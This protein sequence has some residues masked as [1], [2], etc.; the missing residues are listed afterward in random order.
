MKVIKQVIRS[1]LNT[2]KQQKLLGKLILGGGPFLLLCCVCS[3]PGALNDR[4]PTATPIARVAAVNL[5]P[6]QLTATAPPPTSLSTD[7]PTTQP[8]DTSVPQP[9]NTPAT[10]P[11][12]TDDPNFQAAQVINVVDGNTIDVLIDD[13]E[14]QVRYLL[15]DTQNPQAYEANRQLV[16]G[17]T[18]RLE[19]DISETDE[20][21]RL[22]RYVY[23]GPLIVQEDLLRSGLAQV[24]TSSSDVKYLDRFMETQ[25]VAQTNGSGIWAPATATPIPTATPL[26]TPPPQSFPNPPPSNSSPSCCK[27]CSAGKACG[28]SCIAKDKSCNKPPG[29]ACN[30]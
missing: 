29:C 21:G 23:I 27:V 28:D 18:V 7:T 30:G 8:T 1:Y 13:Q 15:I 19:K 10:I 26:P 17:K 2:F 3:L 6:A 5:E 25:Q 9:T 11:T 20:Q 14:Y 24:N 12:P 16:E 22:L 4:D